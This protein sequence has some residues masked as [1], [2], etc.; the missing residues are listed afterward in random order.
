MLLPQLGFAQEP[1]ECSKFVPAEE[2]RDPKRLALRG[3]ACFEAQKYLIA[4][5]H[6]RRARELSDANLLNAALGRT[7]HELG[8]P[9]IARRYYRDYLNGKIE[10]SEGGD[11]IRAR[12]E[13]VEAE[14]EKAPRVRVES[15]PPGATIFLVIE[16]EHREDLGETPMEVQMKPGKHTFEVERKGYI[17]YSE[18]VDAG[19]K[20][21]RIVNARMVREDATFPVAGKSMRQAGIVTMVAA[22]PFVAGGTTLYFIGR[23]E[24]SRPMQNWGIGLTV[25]GVAAAGTGL[26]LYLLGRAADAPD[27]DDDGPPKQKKAQFAPY[28]DGRTAGVVLTF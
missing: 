28:L 16:G 26:T 8:Y 4:L 7:F 20:Q 21:D 27:A 17:T 3:V 14:L 1:V 19:S 22:V 5:R 10:D 23:N 13:S 15:S 18:V 25:V 2:R 11:K 6:Y 12:L 9:Y 24:R